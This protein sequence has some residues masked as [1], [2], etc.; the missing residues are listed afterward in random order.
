MAAWSALVSKLLWAAREKEMDDGHMKS[1]AL[2]LLVHAVVAVTEDS[3]PKSWVQ[4]FS[5]LRPFFAYSTVKVQLRRWDCRVTAALHH[6]FA[7]N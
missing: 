2:S 5:E 6:A 7:S 3:R 4:N 1:I